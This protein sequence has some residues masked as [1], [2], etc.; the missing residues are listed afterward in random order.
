ML[1]LLLLLLESVLPFS[2]SVAPKWTL[3][4]IWTQVENNTFSFNQSL[5][6][7]IHSVHLIP[8]HP[9]FLQTCL[10]ATRQVFPRGLAHV[11]QF[12]IIIH[13]GSSYPLLRNFHFGH[14]YPFEHQFFKSSSTVSHSTVNLLMSARDV[15]G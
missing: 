2:P 13:S 9:L 12:T 3:S 11:A 14:Q 15:G 7:F 1:L 6:H 4:A 5:P 10:G 8:L